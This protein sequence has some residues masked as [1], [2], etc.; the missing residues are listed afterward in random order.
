MCH[1]PSSEYP[2]EI[3]YYL[4]DLHPQIDLSVVKFSSVDLWILKK[5]VIAKKSTVEVLWS[6]A[7]GIT[8]S[9]LANLLDF[10]SWAISGAPRITWDLYRKFLF[11]RL[12]MIELISILRTNW[13]PCRWNPRVPPQTF[14]SLCLYPRTERRQESA[15]RLWRHDDQTKL[16][17]T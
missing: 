5:L 7:V 15:K 3:Q 6:S 12:W 14:A 8:T 17:P 4:Y 10:V 2:I 16:L 1:R 9:F 11:T 13:D